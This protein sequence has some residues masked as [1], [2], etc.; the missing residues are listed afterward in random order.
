MPIRTEH[1]QQARN[2]A[3]C[4]SQGHPEQHLPPT[5]DVA[6]Q[7]PAGQ[8]SDKSGSQSRG[9]FVAD[10]ACR[11]AAASRPSPAQPGST[12]IRAAPTLRHT[13]GCSRS[14]PSSG[15][16]AHPV[17][18]PR[19]I[20]T[21]NP[22]D[23]LCNKARQRRQRRRSVVRRDRRRCPDRWRTRGVLHLQ[24]RLETRTDHRFWCE[25]QHARY[26]PPLRDGFAGWKLCATGMT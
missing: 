19:W 26:T 13:M 6:V 8:R 5:R 24:D 1:P 14:C 15:P 11:S 22:S 21:V 23:G 20:H 12:A 17:R 18:R 4:L 3:G 9:P 16:T 7:G 10:H 25:G 2:A